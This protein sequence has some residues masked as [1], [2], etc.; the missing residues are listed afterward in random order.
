M[1]E[2]VRIGLIG[3]GRH[4]ARYA[5]H[6]SRGEVNG[7]ALAA[8]WRRD[9]AK[10]RAQCEAFGCRFESDVDRLIAAD[11]V[12][13]LAVV[14]P[15]GEHV[16]LA[17]RIAE[18]QKP[19]L[20]EKPMSRTVRE[21][22]RICSAFE[23]A[24]AGLTIAQT[25]RFDPLTQA[26]KQEAADMGR[27]TGFGFEQRLENRGLRWEDDPVA[28]GGGVLIQTAI[29]TIDALRVVTNRALELVHATT[30]RVHYE[31]NEDL[32]LLTLS[33][34][35]VL[36]DVRASKIGRSRHM[37]FAL[38]FEDGGLEADYIDRVLYVTRGRTR[39]ARPVPPAATVP[40][41]LSSFVAHVR[42]EGANPVPARDALES[43]RVIEDAYRYVT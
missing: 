14:V 41:L 15:V 1:Y 21:G 39:T 7:A 22:D 5:E 25:L 13:A 3:L 28:S 35:G 43:L 23:A 29:H 24:G 12:D 37:R 9:E 2:P 40:A 27:L 30:A 34:E 38:Y 42:G 8:A 20:L 31:H 33:A 4:G 11:D 26:L 10:G 17:C 18:K 19:L 32:A 36:G 16:E 6:L